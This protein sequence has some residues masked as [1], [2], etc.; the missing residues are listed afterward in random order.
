MPLG[1]AEKVLAI[2]EMYMNLLD[3][4]TGPL[5]ELAGSLYYPSSK[6]VLNMIRAGDGRSLMFSAI[7]RSSFD[8]V[9]ICGSNPHA[10]ICFTVSFPP[11]RADFISLDS[12]RIWPALLIF[13]LEFRQKI[14][15]LKFDS[16]A[17]LGFKAE[18]VI[19]R[20]LQKSRGK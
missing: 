1:T 4:M 8:T 11:L 18:F 3:Q 12:C 16:T 14:V 2:P 15:G 7:W 10:P 17:N 19:L 13:G 6:S 9:G 5:N 20:Q